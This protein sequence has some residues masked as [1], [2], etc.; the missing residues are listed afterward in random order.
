MR[1]RERQDLGH[2]PLLGSAGE[3]FGDI[4]LKLDWSVHIKNSRATV[5][6][7]GVLPERHTRG[8]RWVAKE[9]I[10]HKGLSG[11]YIRNSYLLVTMRTV[12]RAPL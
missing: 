10:Y 6:F 8:R 9:R 7:I 11:S 4:G 1:Q 12:V 5:S 3:S 2:M